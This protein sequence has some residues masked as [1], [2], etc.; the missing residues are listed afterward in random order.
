MAAPGT[1]WGGGGIEGHTIFWG[2]GLRGKQ[3]ILGGGAI[4]RQTNSLLSGGGGGVAPSSP[5]Y[6]T[7][8]MFLVLGSNRSITFFLSNYQYQIKVLHNVKTN[9][10]S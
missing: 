3:I 4:R 9:N 7:N 6:R 10:S 8:H 1:N 2:G 5:Y